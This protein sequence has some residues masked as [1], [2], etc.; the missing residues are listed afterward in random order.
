[1]ILTKK[2]WLNFDVDLGKHMRSTVGVKG[3]IC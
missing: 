1:M 2:Q 3:T